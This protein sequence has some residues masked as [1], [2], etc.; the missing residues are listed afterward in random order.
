MHNTQPRKHPIEVQQS[1]LEQVT[2]AAFGQRRKMLR[3]SLKGIGGQALLDKVGIN[4]KLRAEELS[5]A[6]F[7]GLA[8]AIGGDKG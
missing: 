4:G 8:N 5:T 7:V 2:Q 6:E 3:Q 1:R